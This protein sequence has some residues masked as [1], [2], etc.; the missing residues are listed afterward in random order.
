[1]GNTWRHLHYFITS[2]SAVMDRMLVIIITKA[3]STHFNIFLFNFQKVCSWSHSSFNVG[4]NYRWIH[5][6]VPLHQHLLLLS[7]HQRRMRQR[8]AHS[9]WG[10]C[11]SHSTIVGWDFDLFSE[12]LLGKQAL[13]R[14][15]ICLQHS[16]KDEGEGCFPL[17]LTLSWV[18]RAQQVTKRRLMWLVLFTGAK[19]LD[20]GSWISHGT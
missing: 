7:N 18:V 13:G 9:L 3:N 11:V 8:G 4:E 19:W 14:G 15:L 16:V 10:A 5:T 17:A 20:R 12:W 6:N 1:M 2:A